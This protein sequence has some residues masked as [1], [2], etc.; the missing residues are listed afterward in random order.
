MSESEGFMTS[1]FIFIFICDDEVL[2]DE[3]SKLF[4]AKGVPAKDKSH[5]WNE[6]AINISKQVFLDVFNQC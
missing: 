5:S 3:N 2:I 6:I 4:P 1:H